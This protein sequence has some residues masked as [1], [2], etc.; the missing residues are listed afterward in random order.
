M[1]QCTLTL[2]NV[3]GGAMPGAS[4]VLIAEAFQNDGMG[5]VEI[6]SAM[7][8]MF[9]LEGKSSDARYLQIMG[10]VDKLAAGD[11]IPLVPLYSEATGNRVQLILATIGGTP[12]EP[13]WSSVSGELE[14][15]AYGPSP[16]EGYKKVQL[17]VHGAPMAPE[18]DG[19]GTAAG[20]FTLDLSCTLD[21]FLGD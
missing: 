8:G 16:D 3:S 6:E 5:Y 11:K 20:S 9:G 1:G 14:V 15:V 12:V 13:S 18:P 21:A 7:N 4:N 10:A 17:E 19:P 2:A